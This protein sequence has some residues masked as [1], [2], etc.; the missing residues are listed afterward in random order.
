MFGELSV[1][2]NLKIIKFTHKKGNFHSRLKEVF[3]IF[4]RIEE[5]K[6]QKASTLSGGEQQM[7]AIAIGR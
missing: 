2:E 5:R 1:I 6:N 4:P 7:L 3:K